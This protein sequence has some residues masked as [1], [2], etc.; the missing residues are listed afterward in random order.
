CLILVSGAQK[1]TVNAYFFMVSR[2]SLRVRASLYSLVY[3]KALRLSSAELMNWSS[4]DICNLQQMDSARIAEF[5]N[6]GHHLWTSFVQILGSM[7]YLW[8]LL[9]PASL[10]GATT[11][12]ILVPSTAT[13]VKWLQRVE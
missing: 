1:L 7:A 2:I 13:L 9:G 10:A 3:R 12:V 8:I 6:H 11:M 5:L 4:G